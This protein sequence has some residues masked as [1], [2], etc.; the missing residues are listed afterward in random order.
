MGL[1][2]HFL[3]IGGKPGNEAK[4]GADWHGFIGKFEGFEAGNEGLQFIGN[5]YA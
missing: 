2:S 5:V 4:I 3:C 1:V